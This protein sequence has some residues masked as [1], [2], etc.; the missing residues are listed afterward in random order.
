MRDS[1][2]RLH[3]LYIIYVDNLGMESWYFAHS[4]NLH[5]IHVD[6]PT[7]RDYNEK[8]RGI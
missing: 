6:D 2:L 3:N 1:E 7:K 8:I 4:H 5:I